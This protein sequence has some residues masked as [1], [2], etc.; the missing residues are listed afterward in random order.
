M[1]LVLLLPK[2]ACRTSQTS[3]T[4]D[5]NEDTVARRRDVATERGP[6]IPSE[7]RYYIFATG[8]NKADSKVPDLVL[9]V[10]WPSALTMDRFRKF[11]TTN[12]N[13]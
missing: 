10:P 1:S 12:A 11:S 13:N 8:R 6:R 9:K 5:S 7:G 3:Q 4:P 2:A